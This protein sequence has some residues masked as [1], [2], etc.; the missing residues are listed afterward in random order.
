LSLA[1][2]NST[3]LT[4]GEYS[5]TSF[6]SDSPAP[7]IFKEKSVPRC[8]TAG[9]TDSIEGPAAKEHTADPDRKKMTIIA[10]RIMSSRVDRF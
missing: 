6:A 10:I 5:S 1:A 9:T 3:Q 8:P 4:P 7:T 2:F